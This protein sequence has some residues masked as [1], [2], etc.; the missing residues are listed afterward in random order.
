MK[1]RGETTLEHSASGSDVAAWFASASAHLSSGTDEEVTW[2]RIVDGVLSVVSA[3]WSGITL[4][5]RRGRLETVAS[6]DD[7]VR[8]CDDLQLE[9]GEGPC[10]ESAVEGVG[11]ISSDTEQDPR[12]PRWGPSVAA[13]G[14]RSVMSLHLVSNVGDGNPQLLGAINV[15]DSRRNAFTRDDF[16]RGMV[17]ATHAAQALST[18]RQLKGLES[19]IHSRHMIGLAQGILMER[20][21]LSVAAAFDLMQ[22]CSNEQNL[23]LRDLAAQL[24]RDQATDKGAAGR[25]RP[26]VPRQQATAPPSTVILGEASGSTTGVT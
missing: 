7:L 19:A 1:E 2:D 4:R 3:D 24:V 16:D 14:V 11:F 20:Y 26:A 25:A 13:L 5:R 9:L 8:R 18:V 21:D 6:T 23:K 15:Y 22:R 17:Y 12:W 10:L